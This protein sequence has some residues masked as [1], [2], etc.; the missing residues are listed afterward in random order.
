MEAILPCEVKLAPPGLN[1][2]HR[3]R[4]VHCK[5]TT[6][7][8]RYCYSAKQRYA[9]NTAVN[10]LPVPAGQPVLVHQLQHVLL[11]VKIFF[12]EDDTE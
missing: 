3:S 4:G 10:F 6:L 8:G 12:D 9:W 2:T 5:C 7:T 11:K 1:V